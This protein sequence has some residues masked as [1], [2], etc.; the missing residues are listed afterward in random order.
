MLLADLLVPFI[1][2]DL[3]QA[4]RL[5]RLG[6]A[7]SL[8]HALP[9]YC[10]EA[11]APPGLVAIDLGLVGCDLQQRVVLALDL[12][13]LVPN[14]LLLLLLGF[15]AFVVVRNVHC[16]G[17]LD[18]P[19]LDALVQFQEPLHGIAVAR[20]RFPHAKLAALHAPREI[21]LPFS[22]QQRYGSHLAQVDAN[23][24]IGIDDI[25]GFLAVGAQVLVAIA[26]ILRRV[27]KTGRAILEAAGHAL[28]GDPYRVLELIHHGTPASQ[29]PGGRR[30]TAG[31]GR[32]RYQRAA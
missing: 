20:D 16:R 27:E 17:Q 13:E 29:P 2:H 12:D 9:A 4:N 31:R 19:P 1:P 8:A 21:N 28:L 24:I 6:N 22:G 3:L 5:N 26:G 7:D 32:H 18:I 10:A 30:C 15:G 23:G 14:F 25:V 11:L